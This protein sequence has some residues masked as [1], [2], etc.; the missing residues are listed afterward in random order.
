MKRIALSLSMCLVLLFSVK[1]YFKTVDIATR[2]VNFS[3]QSL[4]GTNEVTQHRKPK[5]AP[6]QKWVPHLRLNGEVNEDSRA[7][8]IAELDQVNKDGASVI[9]LEINTP[10]G[11]IDEGFEMT[12][13]IENSKAPVQCIVDGMAAS[14][15][16]YILQGCSTRIMTTRSLLMAHEPAT[17]GGIGGQPD[18]FKTMWTRLTKLWE[19]MARFEVHRMK[20][21]AKELLEK[22]SHGQEWWIDCDEAKQIGAVDVVVDSVN[23]TIKLYEHGKKP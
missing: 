4:F 18:V 6:G 23:D 9:V 12:K 17:G 21:S 22:T 20:I 15:G 3:L 5:L 8:L 1:G 11:I 7:K 19:V 14:M 10:G 13:A 16:F 2:K